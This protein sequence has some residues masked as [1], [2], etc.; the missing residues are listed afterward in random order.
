M[1][2]VSEN[3]SYRRVGGCAYALARRAAHPGRVEV[4]PDDDPSS[5]SA[6]LGD[7]Y[8]LDDSDSENDEDKEDEADAG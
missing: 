2:E 3:R 1:S 6:S 8:V 4:D 5:T 7:R